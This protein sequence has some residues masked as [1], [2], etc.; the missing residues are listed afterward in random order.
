MILRLYWFEW[1][2]VT[3]LLSL[4]FAQA[5]EAEEVPCRVLDDGTVACTR[6]AFDKLMAKIIDARA[7]RD[8]LKIKLDAAIADRSDVQQALEA[9]V[10]KPPPEPVVIKPTA[11]R[12]LG[13]VV[14]A[15]VGALTLGVAVAGDFGSSGRAS[16]AVVGSALVGAGVIWALP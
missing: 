16:G 10:S 13:P 3:L 1:L 15:A 6:T 14:L 11:L 2:F 5:C 7:E 12:S 8:T 9:C 4:A